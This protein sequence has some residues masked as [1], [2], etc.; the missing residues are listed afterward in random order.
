MKLVWLEKAQYDLRSIEAYY[1][2]IAS[3]EVSAKILQKIVKS[4]KIF[5]EQ[6][7]LGHLSEKDSNI[8]EWHIPTTFYTLVYQVINDE[9]QVLRVFHE[10]QNK[11]SKWEINC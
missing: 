3:K 8:L 4:A 2:D 1:S 10:S 6:P 11:P 5:L 7:Y 9:I